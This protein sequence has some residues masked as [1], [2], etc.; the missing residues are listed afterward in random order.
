[1]TC[2]LGNED[3]DGARFANPTHV[4]RLARKTDA[5]ELAA[6]VNVNRVF[7]KP[8]E[9]YRDAAYYSESGQRFFVERQLEQYQAGAA[10]PLLIIDDDRIVGR[11]TLSNVVRGPMQSATVGYWV[12]EAENS[13]GLASHALHEMLHKA[14]DDMR[15]HRIE[16]GTLLDNVRSQQVLEHNNFVRYGTAP[17]YLYIDGAWRDHAL[18]QRIN[19]AWSS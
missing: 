15:L 16:A 17:E 4:T 7:Q 14:F 9:P 5:A 18:F 2:W 12:S 11:I 8:Y 10:L 6:L 3:C 1:M 13:R 19:H